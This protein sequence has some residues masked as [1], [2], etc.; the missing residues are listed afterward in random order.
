MYPQGISVVIPT[1]G[2]LELLQ[3]L[4]ESLGMA[5]LSSPVDVE[6]IV[7]DSTPQ[8]DKA[9][10]KEAVLHGDAVCL[11][12]SRD[13]RA[14][15]NAGVAA[16][17]YSVILFVDSDCQATS[18][19]LA[20]HW[21]A[22]AVDDGRVGGAAGLTCFVGEAG[23]GWRIVEG[24]SLVAQ[25]SAPTTGADLRWAPC[26]NLS[27]R[28][29]VLDEIGPFDTS[30]PHRLGGDDLDLSLRMTTAGY[31]LVSCPEA[32][33]H[34]SRRTWNSARSVLGRAFRWGRMHYHLLSRHPQART[35]AA[36]SFWVWAILLTLVWTTA[37]VLTSTPLILAIIPAWFGASLLVFAVFDASGASSGSRARAVGRS[38]RG[39]V[40]ELCFTLGTTVESIRHGDPRFI[41]SQLDI[42]DDAPSRLRAA[43]LDSWSNT[44]AAALCT[45]LAVA[46]AR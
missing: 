23:A 41:W 24:T 19:L 17:R 3:R 37:A 30:L 1:E 42:D 25:F 45:L 34:H 36:P 7:V 35:P 2:R 12:G 8:P 5:R 18:G 40:P 21:R 27:Y 28:H 33:V 43:A 14:K 31:R 32:M 44:I 11:D 13:V 46:L 20:A 38:L 16:A 6:V 22:L 29:Q 39:S 9:R 4:L 10:V 26:C 15:R